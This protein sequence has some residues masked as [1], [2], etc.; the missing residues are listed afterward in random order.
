MKAFFRKLG[1]VAFLALLLV[2]GLLAL[3]SV[4]ENPAILQQQDTTP[5]GASCGSLA[6]GA[7][8]EY[9]SQ[10]QTWCRVCNNGSRVIV[11]AG[12]CTSADKDP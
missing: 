2:L 5:A 12:K 8:D 4:V 3:V 1:L 10:G 6:H 7:H 11:H 9:I